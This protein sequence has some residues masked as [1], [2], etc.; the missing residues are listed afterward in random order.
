MQVEPCMS[1]TLSF[2]DHDIVDTVK[3]GDNLRYERSLSIYSYK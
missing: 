2:E 1:K 3:R